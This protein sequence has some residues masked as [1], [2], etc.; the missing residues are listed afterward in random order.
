MSRVTTSAVAAA[1]RALNVGPME[2]HKDGE[3]Q[4]QRA[5]GRYC[6]YYG[7]E[8]GRSHTPEE[9]RRMAARKAAGTWKEKPE[10]TE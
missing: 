6:V 7:A 5:K 10:S 4:K 3:Q 1:L 9:C 8:K 2:G